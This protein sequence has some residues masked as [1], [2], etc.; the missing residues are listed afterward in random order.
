MKTVIITALELEYKTVRKSIDCLE[1]IISPEGTIYEKGK[2]VLNDLDIEIFL[3][4]TG[5]GNERAAIE[6]GRAISFF[7]PNLVLLVGIA[8][9]VKDVQLGDV[10]VADKIYSYESG[11]ADEIFY[12]RPD[13]G[14]SSYSVLQ[15]ARAECRTGNWK[16]E[17]APNGSSN[18]FNVLVGNL[19]A[20]E[21]VVSSTKSSTYN[22]LKKHYNDTTAIEMEGSGF[23]KAIYSNSLNIEAA[24]I[25]GISDLLDNKNEIDST[26]FQEIAVQNA[27][28]FAFYLI[29]KMTLNNEIPKFSK[30]ETSE[31][32]I[33]L[34][35]N[36]SVDDKEKLEQILLELVKVTNDYSIK[37]KK[38]EKGSIKITLKGSKI[39]FE[40]IVD[41]HKNGL[42]KRLLDYEILDITKINKKALGP[43]ARSSGIKSGTVKFFNESKGFG[44]IVD[45]ST[46]K[47]Y[48]VHVSG[49]I[50]EIREG[51]EVEFEIREGRKGLNAANVKKEGNA[52]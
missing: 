47:E 36:F 12:T 29:K 30:V 32:S 28:S 50:D 7:K 48:F 26:G 41:L 45:D 43:S 46:E 49:L 23:V 10:V 3:V 38:V 40:K 33:T 9:G 52:S 27:S 13:L 4:Q 20:G 37:V 18:K 31:Y 44:F 6:T 14:R 25:R 24:I 42:L 51:D 19:C 39:G 22:F 8:G 17:I 34:N 5:V 21:K 15:R 1:E 11:K 35:A 2:Y 16:N